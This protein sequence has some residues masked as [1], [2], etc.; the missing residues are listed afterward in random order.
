MRLKDAARRA[1][2]IMR[3][4]MDDQK[5]LDL[6]EALV[7]MAYGGTFSDEMSMVNRMLNPGLWN[8]ALFM[9]RGNI[10][11]MVWD[12]NVV[13]VLRSWWPTAEIVNRDHGP[14]YENP[15]SFSWNMKIVNKTPE[16]PRFYKTGYKRMNGTAVDMMEIVRHG[17]AIAPVF[18][19]DRSEA[20]FVQAGHIG[21]DFDTG[22]ERSLLGTFS[23]DPLSRAIVAFGYTTPSHTPERPKSRLIIALKSPIT[24]PLQ[25]KELVAALQRLYPSAD[26]AA[27][28]AARIFYGS[29]GCQTWSNWAVLTDEHRDRILASYREH[30]K[31]VEY[32]AV[33]NA[34]ARERYSSNVPIHDHI[35]RLV[36][37]ISNAP[38]GERHSAAWR[39]GKTVG[40]YIAAGDLSRNE[41]EE[42]LRSGV[43]GM[44]PGANK[45]DHLRTAFDGLEKGLGQPVQSRG[46]RGLNNDYICRSN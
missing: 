16:S 28:D 12:D 46:A 8:A 25:Y 42:Y 22:D 34:K 33:V 26:P 45:D 39:I 19:G 32:R 40:G 36:D 29:K 6:G 38:D 10:A 9:S 14:A 2:K 21:L 1:H 7:R 37:Q 24:D 27:S 3:S 41:G 15:L 35:G 43:L 20:N 30:K 44:D 13:R 18:N 5:S 17:Y 11:N 31:D 4:R 23:N